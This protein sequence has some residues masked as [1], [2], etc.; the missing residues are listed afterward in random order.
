MGSPDRWIVPLVEA[1]D[2]AEQ[3]VGG[4]AAKLARLMGAGFP[5][6]NGFCV[7][8]KAYERF[9]AEADL[10]KYVAMELGRKSLDGMRWEEIWDA[11]L[12]IRSEFLRAEV[13]GA[14][15]QAI[16]LALADY[17]SDGAV[18]VRSSAPGE[19]SKHVSFAG[20]HE[21]IVGVEGDDAVRQA[22][23]TVWAS[24]WSDAALL[25]RRE[26]A[27]DPVHSQ[28]AVLVQE[29]KVA[30]C[31]GVAFGR[32]PRDLQ[33]DCA[34]IEAVP[35][36]CALLVDGAVDPDRWTLRRSSGSLIQWRPGSRGVT[37]EEPLLEQ[38]DLEHLLD[39][40]KRVEHLLAWPPDIEWTGQ[41]A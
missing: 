33:A 8:T 17:V 20:L 18:A 3:L 41:S 30:A 9:L 24:L 23:R 14:I 6:P 1:A 11:A 29:V 19:D 36:Q 22:V 32:D 7:T 27:L 37:R 26:L 25:Y 28:M 10:A 13:P 34:I 2:C 5:V 4:K 12:R 31:S 39:T 16:R 40:L 21:S 38:A 35:G 15:A